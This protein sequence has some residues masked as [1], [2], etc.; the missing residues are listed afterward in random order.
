MS[1]CRNSDLAKQAVCGP[2]RA[3]ASRPLNAWAGL[4][5]SPEPASSGQPRP[6][7]ATFGLPLMSNVRPHDELLWI[8]TELPPFNN[9]PAAMCI[10]GSS[11][12][13]RS[14]NRSSWQPMA[15]RERGRDCSARRPATSR[16]FF[17]RIAP[18][19][20]ASSP[21]TVGSVNVLTMRFWSSSAQNTRPL[22]ALASHS[23][24]TSPVLALTGSSSIQGTGPPR[25]AARAP[26]LTSAMLAAALGADGGDYRAPQVLSRK[27]SLRKRAVLRGHRFEPGSGP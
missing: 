15:H 20:L 9:P 10:S 13:C 26:R 18:F 27:L 14:E 16:H 22:I 21:S 5:M 23:P 12:S 6:C 19:Q 1:T 2:Q 3:V 4:G 24:N 25:M 11:R 8:K 7:C 17:C